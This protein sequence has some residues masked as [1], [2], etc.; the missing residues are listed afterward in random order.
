MKKILI[1]HEASGGCGRHVTDLVEGLNASE[2]EIE[3]LYGALRADDTYL[4]RVKELENKAKFIPSKYLVR[5]LNPVKDVFAF[6]QICKIISQFCPDIVHCHSS[7]AGFLGRVSAKI[8]GVKKI[9]YTP[10]AYSFQSEEFGSVKRKVFIKLEQ[11]CSRL[12]TTC[13]FNV[14]V[15]ERNAALKERIDSPDKFTVIYNGISEKKLPDT[16]ISRKRMNISVTKKVIGTVAR[17]D[18]Q[19]NPEMFLEIAKRMIKTDKNLVFVYVGDGPQRT[20]IEKK[21][22]NLELTSNIYIL[23]YRQDSDEIVSGFDIFL[24]TSMYEGMPYALI[25]ALRAGVPIVA[26]DVTGNNEVVIPQ[27]NGLLFPV[28]DVESAISCLNKML[29][30]PISSDQIRRTF[31]EKFTS[32]NMVSQIMNYYSGEKE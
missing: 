9:F 32:K 26:T 28:G 4:T 31:R 13:T 11:I 10:H 15:G 18:Q 8:L 3:V 22:N 19:K 24:S 12:A 25:E 5:D 21:I 7:K 23:G 14:S 27:I 30:C 20:N 17:I 29:S 2:Y 6:I 1:I 16:G